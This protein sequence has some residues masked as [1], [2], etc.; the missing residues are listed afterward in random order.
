MSDNQFYCDT[1]GHATGTP[2]FRLVTPGNNA[3]SPSSPSVVLF[4]GFAPHP[5]HG[6]YAA[7]TASGSSLTYSVETTPPGASYWH[8]YSTTITFG[9]TFAN[10]P[11]CLLA[12]QDP[13]NSLWTSQF[14]ILAVSTTGG[15]ATGYSL[16]AFA[17]TTTTTLT[18]GY[19]LVVYPSPG[20]IKSP[21]SNYAWRVFQ[22]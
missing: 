6:T 8:R 21:P 19:D 4:D 18:F 15:G 12:C 14:M 3:I 16:I 7:G 10:P 22:I 13:V 5:Y 17:V 2:I 11:S 1:G 9:K 20:T